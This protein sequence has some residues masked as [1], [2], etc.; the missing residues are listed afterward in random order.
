MIEIYSNEIIS[1]VNNFKENILKKVNQLK[2]YKAA[3][4]KEMESQRT[5]LKRERLA[6]AKE[7]E[8]WECEKQK[9]KLI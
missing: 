1:E 9:I 6:V 4:D 2:E 5:N 3:F 7:R 8:A